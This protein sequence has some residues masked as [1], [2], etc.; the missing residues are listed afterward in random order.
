MQAEGSMGSGVV[1]N[2]GAITRQEE[3]DD[4]AINAVLLLVLQHRLTR[5]RCASSIVAVAA[6]I[7]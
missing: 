1:E 6:K 4:S 2:I 3:Y 7:P 5:S